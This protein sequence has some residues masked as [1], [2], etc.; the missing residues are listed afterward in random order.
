LDSTI[1]DGGGGARHPPQNPRRM[2][3]DNGKKPLRILTKPGNQNTVMMIPITTI[4]AQE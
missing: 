3:Y 2:I 1:P 4:I